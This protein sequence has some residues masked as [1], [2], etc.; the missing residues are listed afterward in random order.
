MS[1]ID[2]IEKYNPAYIMVFYTIKNGKYESW[3]YL[4]Y[5][6]DDNDKEI[7]YYSHP[8][9]S[10]SEISREWSKEYRNRHRIEKVFRA[11]PLT[12]PIDNGIIIL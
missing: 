12:Q 9:N 1:I 10:F 7:G 4:E 2:A 3:P 11:T 6:F 8:T 5:F